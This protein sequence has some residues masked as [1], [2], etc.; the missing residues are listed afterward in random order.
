[1]EED[2]QGTIYGF[3]FLSYFYRNCNE[4]WEDVGQRAYLYGD[5]YGV[6]D[7]ETKKDILLTLIE[8]VPHNLHTKVC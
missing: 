2:E 3:S 4:R 6:Q 7:R 1:M 5:G 8:P